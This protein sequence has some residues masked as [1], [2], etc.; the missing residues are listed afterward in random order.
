VSNLTNTE[1][2]NIEPN[3]D[4]DYFISDTEIKKLKIKITSKGGQDFLSPLEK[5]WKAKQVS[6]R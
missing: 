4:K 3:P 1:L 5:E 6:D 2:S